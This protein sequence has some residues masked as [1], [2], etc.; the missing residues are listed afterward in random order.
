MMKQIDECL[1]KAFQNKSPTPSRKWKAF[2]QKELDGKEYLYVFHYHH[3]IVVYCIDTK[4]YT[5]EWWEKPTDK[6]GLDD[7]KKW[8]REYQ[9]KSSENSCQLV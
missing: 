6:R 2:I 1:R 7:I 5:Y 9:R 3:L 8:L 4:D